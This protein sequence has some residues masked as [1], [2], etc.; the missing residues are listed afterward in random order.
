[1][2]VCFF[3]QNGNPEVIRYT[4]FSLSNTV[5]NIQGDLPT[6]CP[7][8]E[9]K[10]V[11]MKSDLLSF[12]EA[13]STHSSSSERYSYKKKLKERSSSLYITCLKKCFKEHV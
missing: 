3:F 5:V 12:G 2:I 4:R 8:L 6:I 11:K 1:M 13:A 7:R 9:D 10:F